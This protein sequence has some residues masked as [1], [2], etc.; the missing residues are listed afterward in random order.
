MSLDGD[1]R[2]SRAYG[3]ATSWR[4][5][6]PGGR[7]QSLDRHHAAPTS[8]S[9]T[10]T[11]EMTRVRTSS[12]TT[13]C[14]TRTYKSSE[15]DHVMVL[16]TRAH[17][18]GTGHLREGVYARSNSPCSAAAW[19]T[20]R[21]E[22]RPRR[23]TAASSSRDTVDD[24]A[25]H[26]ALA[27]PMNQITR[28]TPWSRSSSTISEPTSGR[29]RHPEP[30]GVRVLLALDDARRSTDA[31]CQHPLHAKPSPTT[32]SA[33]VLD[34]AQTVK[35]TCSLGPRST[36]RLVARS[37]SISPLGFPIS[38]VALTLLRRV[39]GAS[40]QVLRGAPPEGARCGHSAIA[41]G[42]PSVA[43][44]AS[45]FVAALPPRRSRQPTLRN[46]WGLSSTARIPEGSGTRFPTI[47]WFPARTLRLAERPRARR[48]RPRGADRVSARVF[49]FAGRFGAAGPSGAA[50]LMATLAFA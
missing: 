11:T 46:R 16:W 4:L 26:D 15:A 40:R 29:R 14:R 8:T 32:S 22:R 44:S 12:P 6:S 41:H 27:R 17:G 50:Y 45:A 9:T 25:S 2:S 42:A 47:F 48:G 36:P 18:R 13:R 10:G 19:G 43:A 49:V 24:P 33:P 38:P 1:P 5:L 28:A 23:D 7:R 30:V 31:R 3:P 37:T 20:S 21:H 39:A 35:S 34:D